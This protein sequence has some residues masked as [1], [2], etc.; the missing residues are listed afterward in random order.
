MEA[1]VG[2]EAGRA[3]KEKTYTVIYV[4]EHEMLRRVTKAEVMHLDLDGFVHFRPPESSVC[5]LIPHHR[6]RRLIG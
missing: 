1:A 2:E 3:P 5:Y 4:D 6:V